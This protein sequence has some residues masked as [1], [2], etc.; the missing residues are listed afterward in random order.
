MLSFHREIILVLTATVTILANDDA[1]GFVYFDSDKSVTLEEPAGD[2]VN[3]TMVDLVIIRGPGMYG[4][5]NV[6]FEVI[7]ELDE[8]RDDL[9]PMQ[10]SVTFQDLQVIHCLTIFG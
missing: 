10:G 2:N 5:V 4:I 6:P 8:N 3:A 9:S 7:P 1:R